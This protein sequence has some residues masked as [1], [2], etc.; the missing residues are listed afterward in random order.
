MELMAWT[1][2]RLEESFVG[3][4]RRFEEI[5]RRFDRL[6]A[7]I[8]DLRREMRSEFADLRG[9]IH[10]L[11]VGLIAGLVAVIGSILATGA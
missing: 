1:D 5:D 10:R 8:R 2:E 11:N 7:E 4:D 3:I 9:S 6:E